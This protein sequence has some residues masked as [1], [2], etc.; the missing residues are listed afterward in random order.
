[1][2]QKGICL[3]ILLLPHHTLPLLPCPV[4]TATIH[5]T[6]GRLFLKHIGLHQP[7]LD[8]CTTFSEQL[9]FVAVPSFAIVG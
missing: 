2:A 1:L 8:S 6:L 9:P 3:L 4:G 7:I 5:L